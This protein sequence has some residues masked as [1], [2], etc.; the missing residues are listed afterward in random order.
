MAKR[1][2]QAPTPKREGNWWYIHIRVDELVQGRRTR[3]KKR[4][5]L[6]PASMPLR[7]VEKL[8][9]EH[10]RPLNQGL[11]SYGAAT[12]LM[13]FVEDTYRPAIM[14]TF[15]K[16]T[17][18]R[19]ESVLRL[20]LL[21]QFGEM[22]M[23]DITPAV[24]Q[25]YISGFAG[26]GL[27]HETIDKIRDVLA[28]ALGVAVQ[29]GLLVKNPAEGVRLPPRKRRREGKR[30]L[31][32]EQF[33]RLV[34][35]LPEPYATM[36]F[37]AGYTGLRPSELVALRWEDLTEDSIRIDERCHRGDW[38]QPKSDA[39][40]A[41]VPV[42]R[43]V[44]KRIH[45]L[46]ILTVPVKAGR[47]TRRVRV[48][49]SDRP[50]DVVFQPLYRGAAINDNNILRRW[51][52]PIGKELG[53][54][55]VNWQVLRRSYATWLRMAGADPKDAQALMRHSRVTTTLE[56]YQQH[57]PASQRRVTEDFGR[58]MGPPSQIN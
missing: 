13:T 44:I 41:T 23:S 8:A 1:R 55:W 14:P 43:E 45:R 54:E 15:S 16:S 21:P 25:K 10:L 57:I 27:A 34:E 3:H 38:S 4:I 32:P 7:Q 36:V 51:I 58:L 17:R 28:S 39:S 12:P 56:I 53:F 22:P 19:Y 29:Y 24:V 30:F 6:A 31:E 18:D 50:E 2:F 20:H 46:R 5:K 48:V 52:K 33:N 42:P 9:A 26:S 35:R 47:G 40:A 11:Q 37:T 49:K